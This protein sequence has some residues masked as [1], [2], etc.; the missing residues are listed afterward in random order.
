MSFLL[1]D[2][3]LT[4]TGYFLFFSEETW[5]IH[6]LRHFTLHAILIWNIAGIVGLGCMVCGSYVVWYRCGG[7]IPNY[8]EYDKFL[9]DTPSLLTVS[10]LASFDTVRAELL[11]K[12]SIGDVAILPGCDSGVFLSPITLLLLAVAT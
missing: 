2:A 6:W 11:A 10:L 7:S 9:R 12:A 3:D 1:P 4:Y 5:S 8:I